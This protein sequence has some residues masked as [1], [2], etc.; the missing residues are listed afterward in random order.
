MESLKKAFRSFCLILMILLASIGVGL[1]GGIPLPTL[2]KREDNLVS[3][4]LFELDK[5]KEQETSEIDDER[6]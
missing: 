2:R 6:H 4:E 1:T 5:M 3:I